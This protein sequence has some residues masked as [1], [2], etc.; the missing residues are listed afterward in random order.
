MPLLIRYDLVFTGNLDQEVRRESISSYVRTNGEF[1]LRGELPTDFSNDY[2]AGV[3]R[4]RLVA[5]IVTQSVNQ[6]SYELA[7]G[8]RT[9]SG[10][11]LT[12][13]ALLERDSDYLSE[14]DRKSLSLRAL[15]RY[16]R[17]YASADLARTRE[18]QDLYSRDR[19]VGRLTLRRD[20]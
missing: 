15:W 17:F 18:T 2:R 20:L 5:D 8:W 10:L 12:A 7:F 14:R 13:S 19:T 3:R 1:Y 9:R 11:N 16:R 4:V 6:T